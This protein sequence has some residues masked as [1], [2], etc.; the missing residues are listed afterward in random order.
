MD[1]LL[2]L[3]RGLVNMFLSRWQLARDSFESA[4]QLDPGSLALRNNIAICTFY[5]GHLKEVSGWAGVSGC[6]GKLH[7]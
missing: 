4:L 3:P 5:Q 6:M 7:V 1:S 2:R